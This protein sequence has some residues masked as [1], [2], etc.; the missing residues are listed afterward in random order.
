MRPAERYWFT[1]F[2][3]SVLV[4]LGVGVM[5]LG[6]AGAGLLLFLPDQV[7][8]PYRWS[9]ILAAA[10]ALAVGLLVGAPLVLVGRLVPGVPRP[11]SAPGQDSAPP[12]SLGGRAGGRPAPPDAGSRA[13]GVASSW[14][15]IR[16]IRAPWQ[17]HLGTRQESSARLARGGP[18][19]GAIPS[20]PRKDAGPVEGRGWLSRALLRSRRSPPR[21]RQRPPGNHR[22][23]GLPC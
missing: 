22:C 9:P 1:G 14:V 15:P 19:A 2:W 18:T 10:V 7:P 4:G 21:R 12:E 13:P 17:G 16:G 8:L 6:V 5:V 3:A 23:A 11:A 20:D